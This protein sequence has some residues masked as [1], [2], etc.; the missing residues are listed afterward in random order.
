[1]R[2]LVTGGA[3]YIGSILV[4]RLLQ[5]GHHVL[6]IDNLSRGKIEYLQN[7]QD[8]PDFKL[9]TG[10]ITNK[11][12]LSTKLDNSEIQVT[13]HLAAF[14]GL[15]RCRKN[16]RKAILTNILGTYNVLKLSEILNVRKFIFSSSGA[17]Y[18]T[19]QHFPID[20]EHPLAPTN[21]Y[22]VSKYSCEKLVQRAHDRNGLEAIILR[23]GNIYGVG[24]FTYFETV[25]PKFVKQALNEGIL[26]IYGDGNQGRDFIHI[27]DI[28]TAI[29]SALHA[30]C[31]NRCE[32]FNVGTGKPVSINTLA[33]L[34]KHIVKTRFDLDIETTHYP[35]RLGE[36]TNPDYSYDVTKIREILKFKAKW[37]IDQGIHQLIS[38]VNQTSP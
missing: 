28:V 23:F 35:A 26:T 11:K 37:I 6:V 34:I 5:L 36:P 13:I 24:K 22:G 19:P 10:D 21:I 12:T 15:A 20:E 17:V 4:D 3:G 16:P 1:M 18:G 29:L 14:P 31:F 2:V 33:S 32:V 9:I 7:Q 38:Y 30:P 8:N 25:I 27:S